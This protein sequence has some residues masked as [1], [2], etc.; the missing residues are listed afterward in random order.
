[1]DFDHWRVLG[2]ARFARD[3]PQHRRWRR[4]WQPGGGVYGS[5]GAVLAVVA[6][7]SPAR[8]LPDLACFALLGPFHGYFPTYSSVFPRNLNSLTWA[9]LKAHT[10]NRAGRVTL[11]SPNP[12]DPPHVD[13]RYFEE[14]D[15]AAGEDL[16]S[17]VEGIRLV[18]RLTAPLRRRGLVAR[19]EVPGEG[20]STDDELRQFVRDNAWGH[21]ASC[22][23]AIGPRAEGGVL[24]SDFRVHGTAG[25]RVVDASVFPRIPGFFPVGAVYMA[26]EKAAEAILQE[27]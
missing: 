23:C 6:K 21:H 9:I 10:R 11:R 22:T 24:T 13:F 15:D 2:G 12:R 8:P 3:D 17:V 16:D 25:L 26:A 27:R 5:N 7:S 18:R 14:G 19:E 4:W 1:M 20:V